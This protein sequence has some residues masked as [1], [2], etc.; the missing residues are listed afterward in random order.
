MTIDRRSFLSL[1]G[2]SVLSKAAWAQDTKHPKI[3]GVF[4][5]WATNF[6]PLMLQSLSTELAKRGWIIGA[7]IRLDVRTWN[8]DA[9]DLRR[10][11]AE[12]ISE[13]CDVILSVGSPLTTAL[14]KATTDIPIVFW[15]I[16]DPVAQG[17][18]ASLDH[19][20]RNLTG[21]T[22]VPPSI[23]G[24]WVEILKEISPGIRRIC[25]AFSSDASNYATSIMAS[26][27][28][29]AA[30]L[31]LQSIRIELHSDGEILSASNLDLHGTPAGLILVPGRFVNLH[32]E[33][34]AKFSLENR[35]PSIDLFREYPAAG[36]LMSYGVSPSEQY[37]D[38]PLYVD[39]ILRGESPK[40]LPV[41][42][43]SSFRLVINSKTAAILGL[44]VTNS[45]MAMADEVIE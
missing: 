43:P 26:A 22:N 20:G 1:V 28:E 17:L 14:S 38:I 44:T 21:F 27:E 9:D 11:A 5:I 6:E 2:S 32:R 30:L 7:D 12:L 15:G 10:S 16:F 41:Q 19:P 40:D 36:G 18:V 37:R 45:L 31:G 8:G 25:L 3:V 13:R 35:I 29:T 34:L 42:Q 4:G 23:G 33:L 24:K 39:R